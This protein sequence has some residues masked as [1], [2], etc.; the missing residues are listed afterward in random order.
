MQETTINPW[1]S[2]GHETWTLKKS[3]KIGLNM[4]EIRI[5]R[6]IFEPLIKL[7]IYGLQLPW[8]HTGQLDFCKCMD[9]I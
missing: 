7:K 5:L 2:Y 9:H 6:K 8:H 4:W 1:V 3:T